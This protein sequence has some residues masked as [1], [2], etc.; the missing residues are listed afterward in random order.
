MKNKS[1][2]E[3]ILFIASSFLLLSIILMIVVL[4]LLFT[5]KSPSAIP[6]SAATGVGLAIIIRLIILFLYRKFTRASSKSN[7]NRKGEYLGVGLL[8][9]IFGLMYMDGAFA[10]LSHEGMRLVSI[11]MF[12]SVIFDFVSGIM[13][14]V[15][16]FLRPQK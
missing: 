12:G 16:F 10:F 7:K 6:S 3:R 5:D 9:I 14:I 11:L 1:R 13:L 2:N 8:P 4:P 15:L